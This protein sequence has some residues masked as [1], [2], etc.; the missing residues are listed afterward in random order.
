[1]LYS[2]LGFHTIALYLSLTYGNFQKL[3]L[4]FIAYSKNTALKMYRNKEGEY[5]PYSPSE[6]YLPADIKIYFDGKYRGIKWQ[7]HSDD[8]FLG[9]MYTVVATINPKILAGIRDYLTAATF[10][11]MNCAIANFNDISKKISPLLQNFNDY[12]IIRID[13]CV[14]IRLD[15]VIPRYDSEQM[16]NLIKRSD[17]PPHYIEW[18]KYDDTAHRMKSC[19]ES[20]YLKSKSVNINYYS[21]YMQLLNVSQKNIKNGCDPIDQEILNASRN[22]YRF[23]VQ[24]KYHKIYS[25]SQE[26]EKAGNLNFNKYKSL[27]TPLK[28]VEIV[29]DYYKKQ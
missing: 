12:R 22:I 13:Y 16:M 11:D 5:I 15:E 28:C 9:M 24:C 2:S 23:E 21:K 4:D 26:A 7:I 14:N 29:S 18:K 6:N 25:L 27:L 17:I 10:N 20:F 8:R 3:L 19:P 1:M